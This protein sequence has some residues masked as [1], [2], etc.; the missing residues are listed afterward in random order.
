MIVTNRL[1]QL[2]VTQLED[3]HVNN[4][5]SRIEIMFTPTVPHCSMSTLIGLCLRV[6]LL[7]SLPVRFKVDIYVKPG[8]NDEIL[9]NG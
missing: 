2:N 6:K 4:D 9:V 8:M 1:E 5:S 3:V 7:R